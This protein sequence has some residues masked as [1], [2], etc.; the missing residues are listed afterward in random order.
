MFQEDP[1]SAPV[2]TIGTVARLLGVSVHTLRM[3]EKKGLILPSH[4]DSGHRLYSRHDLDRL[5]CIRSAINDE[6][7]SIEG[8][9]RV[10]T[11]IPCWAIVNC[12]AEEREICPAYTGH[13]GPCWNAAGKG[14]FCLRRQCRECVVYTGFAE[15]GSIKHKVQELLTPN[16]QR[17]KPDT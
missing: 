12:P 2:Y 6:K 3:Y 13:A 17:Q 1:C 7:I 5:K 16:H 4:A 8:I 14:S 9:R 15:C 11:L 10:F